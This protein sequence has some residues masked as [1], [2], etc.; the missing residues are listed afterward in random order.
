MM[1]DMQYNDILDILYIYINNNNNNNNNN[2]NMVD[3]HN[4][5]EV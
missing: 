2:T 4:L 3:H 1:H 5:I